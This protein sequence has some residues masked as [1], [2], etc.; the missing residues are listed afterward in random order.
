MQL[1]VVA[2]GVQL[3]KY[4]IFQ[5]L[6]IEFRAPLESAAAGQKVHHADIG[7]VEFGGL[8]HPALGLFSICR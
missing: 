2:M 4:S 7:E 8:D 3:V 6:A 1:A 5:R